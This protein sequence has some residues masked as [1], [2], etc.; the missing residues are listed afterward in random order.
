MKLLLFIL[1]SYVCSAISEPSER[2]TSR[3]EKVRFDDDDYTNYEFI[4]SEKFSSFVET[5]DLEKSK[6]K[7]RD[8]VHDDRR[9]HYSPMYT[10][11]IRVENPETH[12]LIRHGR[13][14]FRSMDLNTHVLQPTWPVK[15]E[16]VVEGDLVLGGL[17]MVHEREDTV[18]CGPVMP[19]GGVQA[20]EAM[21]YTL[22]KLNE[23]EGIVPG[24]K[25]GAH[26]LDDCDKDTYGLE[27][28]VDFIKGE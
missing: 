9:Y 11:R 19:Q 28:A 10:S 1:L 14:Q 4:D 26:I 17:M 23:G 20:L 8:D 2:W 27:M 5:F 24:V 6:V 25:I 7:E 13:R 18:T 3:L 22:D 15:K 21:L 12:H 16:A